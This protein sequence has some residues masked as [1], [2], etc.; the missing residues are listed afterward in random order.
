M[1]NITLLSIAFLGCLS[2]AVT[3]CSKKKEACQAVVFSGGDRCWL[4]RSANKMV[5]KPDHGGGVSYLAIRSS[6]AWNKNHV[7]EHEVV[8]HYTEK[9]AV[10]NKTSKLSPARKASAPVLSNSI[11]TFKFLNFII[12]IKLKTLFN[13]KLITQGKLIF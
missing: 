8:K 7:K 11:I 6:T 13:I 2:L 10:V 1:K 12:F 4:K 9:P 3:G 5:D